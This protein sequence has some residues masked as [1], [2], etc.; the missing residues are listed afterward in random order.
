MI[1]FRLVI[2][3]LIIMAVIGFGGVFALDYFGIFI[4]LLHHEVILIAVSLGVVGYGAGILSTFMGDS[5]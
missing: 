2:L 1:F 4:G 5:R 3:P